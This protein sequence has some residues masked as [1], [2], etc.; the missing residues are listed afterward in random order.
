MSSTAVNGK[1]LSGLSFSRYYSWLMIFLLSLVPGLIIAWDWH[2]DGEDT[3]ARRPVPGKCGYIQHFI[4]LNVLRLNG[5]N[6][7]R[8]RTETSLVPEGDKII[9]GHC[10]IENGYVINVAGEKIHVHGR[11][12]ADTAAA[13][14]EVIP[15][16]VEIGRARPAAG[17]F[18]VQV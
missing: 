3:W 9:L 4:D 11:V 16:G 6:G 5:N 10:G 17:L 14:I 12:A 7:C 8:T 13:D 2:P 18:T 1:Q 15:I